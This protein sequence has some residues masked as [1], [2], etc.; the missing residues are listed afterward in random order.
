MIRYG[1]GAITR[2]GRDKSEGIHVARGGEIA[3]H[4]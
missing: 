3:V 1:L 4:S 2:E